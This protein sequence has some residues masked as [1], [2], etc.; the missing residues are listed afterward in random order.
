MSYVLLILHA[1]VGC[2]ESTFFILESVCCHVC[3]SSSCGKLNIE[4]YSVYLWIYHLLIDL[5]SWFLWEH[6]WLK[7]M[8]LTSSVVQKSQMIDEM[9]SFYVS[10]RD[11]KKDHKKSELTKK[12]DNHGGVLGSI[13]PANTKKTCLHLLKHLSFLHF[14]L[15]SRLYSPHQPIL[16]PETS[17]SYIKCTNGQIVDPRSPSKSFPEADSACD[18]LHQRY[19]LWLF[20]RSPYI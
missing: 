5:H 19:L 12:V 15:L 20:H 14:I 3:Y 10:V 18:L 7:Q 16:N 2:A 11:G 9:L 6:L 4:H 13:K 8:A 17:P 1:L